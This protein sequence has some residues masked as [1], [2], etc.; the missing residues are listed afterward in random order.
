MNQGAIITDKVYDC[1]MIVRVKEPPLSTIKQNQIIMGYLHV[2]KGQNMPLLNKLL[3]LNTTSYAYEE[4]LDKKK[5]RLVNLGKE[6]GIVGMY[7]GLR[8]WGQIQ[9]KN[10]K[11]NQFKKLEPIRKYHDIQ[12]IYAALSRSNLHNGVNVYILGKGKVST[13][14]QNILKYTQ[15]KPNVL[16]RD[17]TIHIENYLSKAD[18]IVNAVDWYP[19]EPRIITKD[20]L[21][22]MKKTAVI[23]DISCD[24][25]GSIESC[26]PTTWE[27]PTYVCDGVTHYCVDNLPSAIPRDS[28]FHLSEMILPHVL[29]V[30]KSD[31]LETGLMTQKG[32]FEYESDS[33]EIEKETA[34]EIST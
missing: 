11:V 15:I 14:A 18:I 23:V 21:K 25:N 9:E 1:K 6:A 13:G 17:Q 2:E 29:K 12:E 24:E 32:V 10:G 31:I 33:L 30:A 26:V 7:E 5:N 20:M 3:D 4:I 8:L 19:D 27:K 28:S 34:I 16:Y 22:F